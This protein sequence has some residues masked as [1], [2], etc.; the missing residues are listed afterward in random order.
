MKSYGVLLR[1]PVRGAKA[2]SKQFAR[3]SDSITTYSGIQ[4][5]TPSG[6]LN[7]AYKDY[8]PNFIKTKFRP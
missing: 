3:N 5:A 7:G 6:L 1:Q 8:D 4:K 2:T